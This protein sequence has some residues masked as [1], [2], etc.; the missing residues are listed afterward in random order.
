MPGLIL[1]LLRIIAVLL[2]YLFLVW[3][4]AILWND[5]R[6]RS[7][8]LATREIPAIMLRPEVGDEAS[9]YRFNMP[10]VTVGRNSSC[11]CPIVDNT[12]SAHH[13]RLIFR[14]NQW[15]VEDL[16]S[17]NGTFLNNQRLHAPIV[18][19]SGD[20]LQFGQVRFVVTIGG[21]QV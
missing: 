12:V 14:N 17:T 5:L 1:L 21:E 20:L 6:Y 13:A 19:T 2:L 9:D 18:L 7:K 11:D 10:Q 16:D 15:W 8:E 4:I 3:V